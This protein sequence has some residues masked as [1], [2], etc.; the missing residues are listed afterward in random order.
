MTLRCAG[1]NPH[2]LTE[3]FAEVVASCN[4]LVR[5]EKCSLIKRL[6]FHAGVSSVRLFDQVNA[7]R[8]IE[9]LRTNLNV[10]LLQFF[11]IFVAI[12]NVPSRWRDG[13]SSSRSS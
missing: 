3:I 9:T 6:S 11:G 8:C 2:F 7:Y 1:N 13:D 5:F 4:Q 10:E 12:V